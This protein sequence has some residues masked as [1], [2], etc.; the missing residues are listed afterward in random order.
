MKN[1]PHANNRKN[2]KKHAKIL[3]FCQT[4]TDFLPNCVRGYIKEATDK[5]ITIRTG[6]EGFKKSKTGKNTRF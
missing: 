1:Y 5:E 3:R 4:K 6:N 2:T